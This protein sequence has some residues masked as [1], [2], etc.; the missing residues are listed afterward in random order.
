MKENSKKRISW[1]LV[2]L[3]QFVSSILLMVSVIKLDALPELYTCALGIV[4][5]ILFL[6][7]VVLIRPRNK[8][9]KRSTIG[10][11]IS[12]LL[13]LSLLV[14]TFAVSQG[15]KALESISGANSQVTR[16]S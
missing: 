4:L 6:I 2:L 7:I 14:G 15:N 13:T 12:F 16:F 1:K 8:H 5:A 11:F 10:K 3:L 9:K